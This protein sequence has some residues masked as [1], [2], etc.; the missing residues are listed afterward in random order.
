MA[1]FDQKPR[2]S[3]R[4]LNWLFTGRRSTYAST[5]RFFR[6]LVE[7]FNSPT[8][9][10]SLGGEV[11]TR[12]LHLRS[13]FRQI[14]QHAES[15]AALQRYQYNVNPLIRALAIWLLSHHASRFTLLGIDNSRHDFSPLVRKRVAKAL[16][17]LEASERLAEMA[18]E[19]PADEAVQRY[20]SYTKH[21]KTYRQRLEK[22]VRTVG[23]RE[24]VLDHAGS[25]MPLWFRDEYW[26][27][28]P[29][30]SIEYMRLLLRRI[31]SLVHG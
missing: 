4:P 20:A 22:F 14:I 16:R 27:G 28:A 7:E 29:P 2:F 8:H 6:E 9:R 18:A 1:I 10:K 24:E 12:L 17:K 19:Y 3:S 13:D 15:A 23:Q 21:R 25:R 31:H 11:T 30:K 26:S 5:E